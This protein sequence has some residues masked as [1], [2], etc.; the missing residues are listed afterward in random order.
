MATVLAKKD[1]LRLLP[2]SN[3]HTLSSIFFRKF[4]TRKLFPGLLH[5]LLP[6]PVIAEY[7]FLN[8]LIT[9]SAY[10][11][12]C[13]TCLITHFSYIMSCCNQY[14]TSCSNEG[15]PSRHHSPNSSGPPILTPAS[16]VIGW[17]SCAVNPHGGI[18][19]KYLMLALLSPQAPRHLS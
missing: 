10:V 19:G 8:C 17:H 5:H 2:C 6:I 9:L 1:S 16:Y 7:A 11:T 15:C 4:L 14:I 18:I 3:I 12:D 13:C